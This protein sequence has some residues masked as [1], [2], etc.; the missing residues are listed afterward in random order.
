MQSSMHADS[1]Y[2]GLELMT[3][4]TASIPDLIRKRAEV[5]P[6]DLAVRSGSERLSY[7]EFEVRANR[8]ANYLSALGVV[9]G[10]IVGLCL[11][12]GLDFPVAALAVLKL[13]AAYLPLEPKAPAKRLQTMLR[14]AGVA[15]VL[16]NC[17]TH[18][19][20]SESGARIV[21]LSRCEEAIE[22]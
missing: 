12:R 17:K 10:N 19:L 21:T 11:E 8:L 20:P 1:G 4:S 13:G 18:N 14:T 16:T 7:Q 2:L 5:S 9:P 6:D 22:R 15:A 3:D